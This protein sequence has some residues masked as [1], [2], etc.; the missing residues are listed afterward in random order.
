VFAAFLGYNP[1]QS[2]LGPSGVLAHLQPA[3]ARYL[4]GRSF[5]PSLIAG[6]FRNGLHEALDFAAITCVI[7]AV[8]SALGGKQYIHG[9]DVGMAPDLVEELPGSSGGV[10][11]G[12]GE[13][14]AQ[15]ER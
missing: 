11:A 15:Q 1:V 6:P 2:L 4:T 12:V 13:G 14:Q 9:E 7:A 8:A 3:Q 5:F 10:L